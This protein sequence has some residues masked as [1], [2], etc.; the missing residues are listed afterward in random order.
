V[1]TAALPS[2][3]AN[4][5]MRAEPRAVHDAAVAAGGDTVA[6][7]GRFLDGPADAVLAEGERATSTCSWSRCW[8]LDLHQH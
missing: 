5:A 7:E 8:M 6:T 3:S 1:T 2:A 4:E